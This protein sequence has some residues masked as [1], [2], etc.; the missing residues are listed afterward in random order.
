MLATP[1]LMSPILYFG[2][3]PVFELREMPQQ[4]GALPTQ[5]P[6]SLLSHPSFYQLSHASPYLATHLPSQPSISPLSHP[7]PFFF[8]FYQLII[9]ANNIQHVTK[10]PIHFDSL[11]HDIECNSITAQ[12]VDILCEIQALS[13]NIKRKYNLAFIYNEFLDSKLNI[14]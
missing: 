2:N 10:Q 12:Y 4:A 9:N 7:S 3:M 5:P 8:T 1:L 11:K 14:Y 6:I 13:V